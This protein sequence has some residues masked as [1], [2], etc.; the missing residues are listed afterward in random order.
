MMLGEGNS[1]EITTVPKAQKGGFSVG[2]Y[3]YGLRDITNV[4]GSVSVAKAMD[5]MMKCHKGKDSDADEV[6]EL[7][8]DSYDPTMAKKFS[9]KGGDCSV[10][11]IT[12]SLAAI[13]PKQDARCAFS[14]ETNSVDNDNYTA[15]CS[16]SGNA[17][18]FLTNTEQFQRSVAST[19]L[20]WKTK[21]IGK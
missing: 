17:Q 18:C 4:D 3:V 15:E 6:D 2:S 13:V 12:S 21:C 8:G 11:S 14:C 20:T 16:G 9:Q 1:D 10:K 5:L 19:F 7:L